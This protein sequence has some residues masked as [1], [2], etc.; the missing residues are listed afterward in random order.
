MENI[1]NTKITI[2]FEEYLDLMKSI[3]EVKALSNIIAD[4]LPNITDPEKSDDLFTTIYHLFDMISA[5]ETDGF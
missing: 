1:E 5:I 2:D 4:T 3:S